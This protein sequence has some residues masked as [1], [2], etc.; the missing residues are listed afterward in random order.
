MKSVNTNRHDKL[1]KFKSKNKV[2]ETK[3]EKLFKLLK[4]HAFD[5]DA[6]PDTIDGNTYAKVAEQDNAEGGGKGE[7]KLRSS[8]Y[9][10]FC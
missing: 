10:L 5:P 3:I 8:N 6:I 7:P 1:D 4:H 9:F 2:L